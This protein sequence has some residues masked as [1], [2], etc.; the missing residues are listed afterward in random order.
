MITG[1]IY[2]YTSPSGKSY[3]GQTTNEA[4][5]RASWFARCSYAGEAIDNA[6][7]KYG[8]DN[9]EYKVLYKNNYYSLQE[10][11]I[12]LDKWECYFIGYYDTYKN[13]YNSTLGGDLTN[14]GRK[15]TEEW[16]KKQSDA[17][18]GQ[19][20]ST[21]TRERI[22]EALKGKKHSK[23]ANESSKIKRRASGMCRRIGQYD[24]NLQLV[25]VWVNG[26]EAAETLKICSSNIYRAIRTLGMYKGYYWRNYNGEQ[27]TTLKKRSTIKKPSLN[28]KI[29]QISLDGSTI[30]T[31]NSIG[32]ACNALHLTHRTCLSRC[33]NG[34]AH[35]AYGYKWKFLNTA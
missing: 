18:K 1:V 29:V 24:V 22:S 3:I 27:T 35:S 7:K 26:M 8:P 33:L 32:E 5:R 15:T 13:G 21:K 12:D 19:I 4:H 17:H 25:K 20:V 9:F 6:R 10:A 14:R 30:A 34:K 28:K 11:T 23:E 31:F 2:M 16:R